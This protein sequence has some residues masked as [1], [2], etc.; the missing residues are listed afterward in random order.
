MAYRRRYIS[1]LIGYPRQSSGDC[2]TAVVGLGAVTGIS[3][4]RATRPEVPTTTNHSTFT[5][6]YPD[7]PVRM[8]GLIVPLTTHNTR[9]ATAA[10]RVALSASV[11]TPMSPPTPVAIGRGRKYD[12]SFTT[13]GMSLSD[14]EK[15]MASKK[16]RA[17]ESPPERQE[18]KRAASRPSKSTGRLSTDDPTVDVNGFPYAATSRARASRIDRYDG[19]RVVSAHCHFLTT[20]LTSC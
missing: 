20:L 14:Q 18:M 12:H 7:T 11:A 6:V 13:R 3:A 9:A 16:R 1:V 15:V 10:G 4:T 17:S 5:S 8:R 19:E 2:L